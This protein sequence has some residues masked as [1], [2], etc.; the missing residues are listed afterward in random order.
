MSRLTK[1]HAFWLWVLPFLL[2][3]AAAQRDGFVSIDCGAT[4]NFTDPVTGIVWST[5]EGFIGTGEN[6]IVKSLAVESERQMRTLRFFSA[7]RRKHC[8]TLPAV[9]NTSYLLRAMFLHSDF[10]PPSDKYSFQVSIDSTLADTVTIA[11]A[12]VNTLQV[13]EYVVAASTDHIDFCLLPVDGPP[14]ISSLELRSLAPAMYDSVYA[15]RYLKNIIR[16]NCGATGVDST[17]RYPD[18]PYDRLWSTPGPTYTIATGK[19]SKMILVPEYNFDQPPMAVMQTAWLG[20]LW[21]YTPVSQYE[22]LKT[23]TYYTNLFFAEIQNVETSDLRAVKVELNGDLWINVNVTISTMQTYQRDMTVDNQGVNFSLSALPSATLDPLVNAAEIYASRVAVLTKTNDVDV[24]A[25]VSV[26]A[27]LG[28]SSWAG[29]P[30]LPVPYSWITCDKSS[31]PRVISIV[32]SNMNLEGTMPSSLG[33]LTALTDLWLDNN[34]IKGVIPD[35]S[36]LKLLKTL[37]LQ[38]NSLAGGIPETLALLPALT[39]LF[40]S[41][42]KLSGP[43]PASLADRNG[44]ILQTAGNVDL[45]SAT[46]NC[47]VKAAPGPEDEKKSSGVSGA[48]IGGAIGGVVVVLLILGLLL[49]L[50]CRRNKRPPP[51]PVTMT[52]TTTSDYTG[53]S[54]VS[55]GGGAL[56]NR[57]VVSGGH[58]NQAR[59]F[60]LAEVQQATN[61]YK[62]K[63]GEGGFGPVY[64]GKLPD[65]TEVAV[66]VNS[67]KSG[68][69]TTEFINEVSLLSRVHHKNLVSLLGYCEESGQQILIYEYM[70]KGTLREHLYGKEM[71]GTLTWSERL[72]IA[73]DAA[74]GLEY[75]HNDCIPKIIHRDIKSNNIL[76]NDKLMSKVADFGISKLAPDVDD[77]NGVSTLVRGTTGYLDPEYFAHNRLTQKSDVYSFGVV[78]LEIMCGRP[79]NS[80][81]HSDSRQYNLIEWTR[82]QLQDSNLESIVD[83]YIKGTYNLESMWKVAELAM[84]SVEPYGVNRPDMKQVVRGLTEALEFQEARTSSTGGGRARHS[85]TPFDTSANTTESYPT[86]SSVPEHP[87]TPGGHPAGALFTP[88]STFM[89]LPSDSREADSGWTD[90][91]PR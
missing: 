68:Q 87:D 81:L 16:L 44:L 38:N 31:S 19:T 2:N 24:A 78:L 4:S 72:N 75:L 13:F 77:T 65:G 86:V 83:P 80:I 84:G 69:G 6:K 9:Y 67:E 48:V 45:C 5:D 17:V 53:A 30:C 21:W 47:E 20:G 50:Y 62:R 7:D 8:Y 89:R 79:P 61:G 33:Q 39:E 41:D 52:E 14:M 29:D 37:H 36:T 88:S 40:L 73:F 58:V 49:C 25:L 18:D 1:G 54:K 55:G 64:Y 82:G 57:S 46:E 60:S 74:K 85:S 91:K 59:G 10:Q 51:I 90:P 76:L 22:L 3:S 43:I 56:S 66:K 12:D 23:V 26:K 32:L 15:G 63:I 35:L 70:S 71:K 28:L 34:Q 27:A 42:N 11:S